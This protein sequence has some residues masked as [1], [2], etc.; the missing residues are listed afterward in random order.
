MNLGYQEIIVQ[1]SVGPRLCRRHPAGAGRLRCDTYPISHIYLESY[2][3]S[4]SHAH[5]IFYPH[6]YA[7]A[8]ACSNGNS[9]TYPYTHPT[10]YS[11]SHADANTDA[12]ARGHPYADTNSGY[13]GRVYRLRMC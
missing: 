11:D 2:S 1:A 10:S 4:L 5:S 9:P 3:D 6:A 13:P 7:D 8:G 12:G